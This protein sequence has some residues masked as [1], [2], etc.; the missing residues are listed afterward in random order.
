MRHSSFS[1]P[2]CWHAA[3]AEYWATFAIQ[4]QEPEPNRTSPD[5][6][7][8]NLAD[9]L[10]QCLLAP[11]IPA[12]AARHV[13]HQLAT[14]ETR[15]PDLLGA[16]H[17]WLITHLC[18]PSAA[19]ASVD[20][21]RLLAVLAALTVGFGEGWRAVVQPMPELPHS[22]FELAHHLLLQ[23]SRQ[24]RACLAA[25]VDTVAELVLGLDA[26]GRVTLF[27]HACERVTGYAAT[28]IV[29]T[30]LW[31][32]FLHAAD[33]LRAIHLFQAGALAHI[34]PCYETTWSMRSGV[35]QPV[36]WSTTVLDESDGPVTRVVCIGRLRVGQEY[37]LTGY[38]VLP[39]SFASSDTLDRERTLVVSSSG[40]GVSIDHLTE[41]LRAFQP[42]Q[43]HHGYAAAPAR[44]ADS[45]RTHELFQAE[46][47]QSVAGHELPELAL[48]TRREREVLALLAQG[49][50]NAQIATQLQISTGT[51]KN[52]VLNL[53]TKL[54]VHS[55]AEAVAVAW[56]AGM[57]QPGEP[58]SGTS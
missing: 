15:V 17:S 16:T 34:P 56:R 41:P 25:I 57:G 52:H 2:S 21:Y 9:Q 53:T 33:V 7:L 27:N 1:S 38:H 6:A 31:E 28:E 24:D 49:H 13:G 19:S 29:G 4:S 26:H 35:T 3:L 10:R 20:P 37:A 48:L 11:D 12:E 51:I 45:V 44:F 30:Y 23:R 22:P 43:E 8:L 50:T 46:R 40:T 39:A 58:L 32:H 14:I 42:P 18:G 5:A 55:R 54:G 47:V 36:V